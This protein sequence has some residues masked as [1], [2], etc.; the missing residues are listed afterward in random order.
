MAD[1]IISVNFAVTRQAIEDLRAQTQQIASV[2]HN[3]EDELRPLIASWEG[4]DQEKYRE[5]QAQWNGAV[6]N[7][8]MLLDST[9]GLLTDIHDG[10]HRDMRKSADNWGSVRVR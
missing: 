9:G 5:V 7:M 1:G 10:H 3:L 2:L 8:G 6:Y 4:V